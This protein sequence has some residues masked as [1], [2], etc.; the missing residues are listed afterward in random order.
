MRR[1]Y[2]RKLT[3]A[4]GI[5]AI[6]TGPAMSQDVSEEIVDATVGKWLIASETGAPGC[7]V[8]LEKDRTIGGRVVTE[9]KPCGSPWHDVLAAWEFSDGGI[10]FRDATRKE[11]ITFQ[12]QEGGPWK[13]PLEVSPTV[14][15]VPNP[16]AMDRVPVAK[17]IVGL[18]ILSDKKGK[19]LCR[20]DFQDKA[21]S[22]LEDAKAIALSSDCSASVKKTKVDAWQISEI[23][24]VVIGGEDWVYT[25][26]PDADGFVSDDGKFHLKRAPK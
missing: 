10:V 24:L 6:L 8:T 17:D 20:I 2:F 3:G 5:A 13:T 4:I 14:Y 18:W 1:D 11:I 16:G 15:F 7:H 25:M 22:R 19:A 12:E 21:S 23:Q 26:T 9:G